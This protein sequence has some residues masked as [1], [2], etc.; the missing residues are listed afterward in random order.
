VGGFVVAGG[1]VVVLDVGSG[2]DDEPGLGTHAVRPTSAM[3]GSAMS[4]RRFTLHGRAGQLRMTQKADACR[5]P[6]A[7]FMLGGCEAAE[8]S[9]NG[10]GGQLGSCGVGASWALVVATVIIAV[11]TRC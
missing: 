5:G 8:P 11:V 7:A 2:N 10:P 1:F 4:G 9:T 3:S 6:A